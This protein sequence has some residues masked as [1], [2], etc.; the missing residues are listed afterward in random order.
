MEIVSVIP[1]LL[2]RYFRKILGLLL[3]EYH[4]KFGFQPQIS[5]VEESSGV[6]GGLSKQDILGLL[7][8]R[9]GFAGA[10]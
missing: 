8:V 1:L 2:P 6:L 7:R 5:G 9:S 4:T 10:R 3:K